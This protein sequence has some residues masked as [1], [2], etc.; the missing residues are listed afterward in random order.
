MDNTQALAVI[1]RAERDAQFC[2]CGQPMAPV[3]RSA[4]VWLECR[5]LP[6][7]AGRGLRGAIAALA[8]TGHDRRLILDPA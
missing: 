4:K 1:E 8:A 2:D 5:A 7:S 3:V 6:S